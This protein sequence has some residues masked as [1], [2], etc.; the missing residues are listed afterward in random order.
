MTMP[1]ARSALSPR[2]QFTLAGWLSYMLAAGVY[3]SMLASIP[4]L[5]GWGNK[6]P[7]LWPALA[8]IP[9]A[10]CVLWWLYRRW[11]L[12]DVMKV[13][14]AGPLIALVVLTI[15][16]AIGICIGIAA[17]VRSPQDLVQQ[18]P[19]AVLWTT[20]GTAGVVLYGCGMSTLISLPAATL[21]LLYLMLRPAAS[22]VCL[23]Q[24][25]RRDGR[26]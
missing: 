6:I 4:P 12:P 2:R 7:T 24:G 10:W 21:M 8:T 9:T 11:R 22:D 25:A 3:F 1:A 16:V 19:G 13:H 14:Y 20:V 17:V 5:I 18:G 23:A 26:E 15:V